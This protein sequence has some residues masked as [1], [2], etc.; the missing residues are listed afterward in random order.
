MVVVV[1]LWTWPEG[2]VFLFSISMR[3]G[4]LSLPPS[5]IPTLML[6][7]TRHATSHTT[8]ASQVQLPLPNLDSRSWFMLSVHAVYLKY[9]ISHCYFATRSPHCTFHAASLGAPSPAEPLLHPMVWPHY[10][11]CFLLFDEPDQNH[12]LRVVVHERII[13][14]CISSLRTSKREPT[15]QPQGEW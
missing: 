2:G 14:S 1:M 6:L 15:S 13:D 9:Y 7:A 3:D 10:N 4:C 5:H 8:R 12:Y 11:I